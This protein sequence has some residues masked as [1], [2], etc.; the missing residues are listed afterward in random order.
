MHFYT[1]L[2]NH[3]GQCEGSYGAMRY[4]VNSRVVCLCDTKTVIYLHVCDARRVVHSAPV[5][6]LG[7]PDTQTP[8]PNS[9]PPLS[10]TNTPYSNETVHTSP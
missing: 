10:I 7:H 9:S 1:T 6:G 5:E 3:R 4:L 2:A 8:I